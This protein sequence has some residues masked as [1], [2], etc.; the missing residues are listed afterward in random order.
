M[1]KW[2]SDQ[3]YF[4]ISKQFFNDMMKLLSMHFINKCII[5]IH[6]IYLVYKVKTDFKN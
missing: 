4:I 1:N 5:Y 3:N 2:L 6:C